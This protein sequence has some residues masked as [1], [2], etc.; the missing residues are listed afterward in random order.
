[1]KPDPSTLI[2]TLGG[3]PQ[4]VTFTLDLLLAQGEQIQDVVIVYLASS[5]RYYQAARLLAGE[6]AG[7][8]YK[9]RA[10]HFR[11]VPVQWGDKKLEEAR[12]RSEVEAVRATFF[13]LFSNL[14]A[15]G[16]R[17]HL[18]VTGGRRIMSLLALSTAMHHFTT[19]DQVWHL[20]TPDAIAEK[21]R[22]GAMLHVPPEEEVHLISVP[23]V[24]WGSYLPGLR[25]ILGTS[26][27]EIRAQGLQDSLERDRC[28][29]VW[30]KLTA[31]QQDVLA[32][33][34]NGRTRQHAAQH[35]AIAITTLDSH[36]TEIFRHCQFVWQD[37]GAKID[38]PFLRERFK[39][40]LLGLGVV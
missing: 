24:P 29:Q 14:K 16:Q 13:H 34:A 39:P 33:L 2:A 19:E 1:M 21:A 9:Q 3:Q 15:Q 6:F 31:R 17:L 38:I 25:P 32:Q 5:P 27:Q 18:S 11:S 4:V 23:L 26:V 22:D 28:R 30:E 7:D 8:K 37:E 36:K 40:F 12:T 10:I 35:L 20:Y